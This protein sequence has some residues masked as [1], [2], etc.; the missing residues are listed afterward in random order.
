MRNLILLPII[1]ILAFTLSACGNSF[2]SQSLASVAGDLNNA[3]TCGDARSKIFDTYYRAYDGVKELDQA[4]FK[5][6]LKSQLATN[7]NFSQ[8]SADIQDRYE[9][10]MQSIH[11]ILSRDLSQARTSIQQGKTTVADSQGIREE[12]EDD[13]LLHLARL[14]MRS[15]IEPQYDPLNRDLDKA[16]AEAAA[17]GADA[18]VSC[19]N[20]TDV[21]PAASAEVVGTAAVNSPLYGAQY[22]M[23]TAYQSCQVLSLA[24][25]TSSVESAQGVVRGKSIDGIGYGR[26]YTDLALLKRTHYY[27]RGQT[28]GPGCASQNA[29]PMVYD[30]GG[31]PVLGASL[32][33]FANSGG[34]GALGID[35]S[36]FISTA[37][38]VAGNLYKPATSNKAVYTRFVSR[39]FINPKTSGWACYDSVQPSSKSSIQSGDIGAVRGHVVMVDKIGADPF[40][41]SRVTSATGC[42]ALSTKNF[43]FT[44]IQ[45]SPEKGSLG[46]NRFVAKDYLTGGGKMSTLFMSYAKAACLAKFDGKVRNPVTSDYGLIRHQ[47]T[48]S[49]LAQK[50]P[51][52][53][54]SCVQN[55]SSLRAMTE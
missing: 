49:C 41:L 48:D 12:G 10:A 1:G 37:A 47:Q 14:E 9:K 51:L 34:G 24:P 43:D 52:V 3:V 29:K 40:G 33:L 8:K 35:C 21:P 38:A 16:I 31:R 32:N 19:S 15:Q 36:A 2:Q 27:H 5:T 25:V 4:A 6:A 39:D 17:A 28:Y 26:E 53:N 22:T 23:A 20:P 7:R 50:I 11:T 13:N 18:G 54:E 46:I 55:C 30:Y 45:S 44:I 42:S